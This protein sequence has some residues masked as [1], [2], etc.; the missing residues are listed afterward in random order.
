MLRSCTILAAAL[1]LFPITAPAAD[2]PAQMAPVIVTAPADSLHV[3]ASDSATLL[4]AAPSELPLSVE[5]LPQA[6]L[7]Q[8]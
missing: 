1:L 2:E 5:V 3:A 7:D 4:A 6:L 8:R